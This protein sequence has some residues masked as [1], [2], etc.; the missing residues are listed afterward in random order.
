MLYRNITEDVGNWVE[1]LL[2]GA[3][4][5]RDGIG[6]RI[7]LSAGGLTQIREVNGRAMATPVRACAGCISAWSRKQS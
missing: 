6:A 7:K 2:A 4:S 5:N 1:L 3:K